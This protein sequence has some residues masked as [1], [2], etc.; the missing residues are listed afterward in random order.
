MTQG[1]A[2]FT[3]L[4]L[5]YL[6]SGFQPFQFQPPH[7]GCYG[8]KSFSTFAVTGASILMSGGYGRLKPSLGNFFLA[9]PK[10]ARA[11]FAGCF[12]SYTF[13]GTR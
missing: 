4:A 12:A 8:L 13:L 11:G 7:V 3:L 9:E 10:A 5:G 1:G 6:L 2:R